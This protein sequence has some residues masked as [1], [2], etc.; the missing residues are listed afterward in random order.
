MNQDL[1]G[2]THIYSLDCY[3]C[4]IDSRVLIRPHNEYVRV[5]PKTKN[6]LDEYNI[7]FPMFTSMEKASKAVDRLEQFLCEEHID[8]DITI[9]FH[10]KEAK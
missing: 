2:Y 4:D 10:V 7:F 1:Q 9:D 6:Y 3:F 8:G 5:F